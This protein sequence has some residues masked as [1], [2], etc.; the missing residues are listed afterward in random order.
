MKL[1]KNVLRIESF[2]MV[3]ETKKLIIVKKY[4]DNFLF[5]NEI[6]YITN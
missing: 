2:V 1:I 5:I 6:L 3:K 4:I